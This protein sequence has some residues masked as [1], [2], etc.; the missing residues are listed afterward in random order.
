V[1]APDV[2]DSQPYRNPPGT[3]PGTTRGLSFYQPADE[4][5]ATT[6]ASPSAARGDSAP[7]PPSY[8][9][10]PSPTGGAS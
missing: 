3:P 8:L 2:S 7:P 4:L 9:Y 5:S 6:S 10:V 1:D